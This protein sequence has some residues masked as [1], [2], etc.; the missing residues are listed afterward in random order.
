[1][2]IDEKSARQLTIDSSNLICGTTMGLHGLL[3]D[4]DLKIESNGPPF[5]VMI[6]DECSKT[7]FQEFIV[8]AILAKRWILVGDIRQL[9]PFTD[10]E[11]ITANLDN[12]ILYPKDNIT[13][14]SE[15]QEA[16]RLLQML[17]PYKDK[18]IVPVFSGVA[19]E[20]VNE[21]NARKSNRDYDNSYDLNRLLVIVN[22]E[23]LI[24]KPQILYEYTT[25]IIEK[26]VMQEHHQWMPKDAV[27]LE[28]RWLQT[29]HAGQHF[30]NR[31]WNA[32]H[33]YHYKRQRI[34]D[35]EDVYRFAYSDVSKKKW[36]DELCWR[37]EREYWLRFAGNSDKEMGI[38]RGLDQLFP[39]SENVRGRVYTIVNIAFPSILESLSDNGMIKRKTDTASTINRGFYTDQRACRHTTLTF[40]HRM[41]PDISSIPRE[42]FYAS[43]KGGKARSLLDGSRIKEKRE[44]SYSRYPE[45]R[46]WLDVKGWANSNENE[47][48]AK[49]I[50]QEIEQFCK[51]ARKNPNKEGTYWEVAVL[52]FYKGQER[53]LREH[54]QNLTGQKKNHSRFEKDG[55]KIKLATVDFFQGQEADIVFLSMVNT[56]RDGFLDSPNRLNVAITRARYQLA[57]VGYHDYFASRS[58]TYELKTLAE[59]TKKVI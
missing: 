55:V 56:T 2:G 4:K 36:S 52:T 6:I 41:H 24:S 40:Q 30:G 15:L 17:S 48:E 9:S 28:D 19:K 50:S 46:V 43:K 57:I 5:D 16:C 1:L 45:H 20:L 34:S 18:L 29:A 32:G 3:R 8:P 58:R 44:W 42:L 11:Q 23:Q 7:T 25:I 31:K 21:I 10:R 26:S 38:K 13:L 53:C 47:A 54:L 39:W 59:K 51:W 22:K 12:L 27:I 33:E 35:S 49:L 37:L 14:S